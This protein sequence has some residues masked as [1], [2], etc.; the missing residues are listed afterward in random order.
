MNGKRLWLNPSL[1]RKGMDRLF[2][3]V[4]SSPMCEKSAFIF[5]VATAFALCYLYLPATLS[6]EANSA[7]AQICITSVVPGRIAK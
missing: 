4:L 2:L 6:E 7:V 3:E 5:V 1:W